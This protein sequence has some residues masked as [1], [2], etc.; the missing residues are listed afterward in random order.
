MPSFIARSPDRHWRAGLNPRGL[1]SQR[2]KT[3]IP[4][5]ALQAPF[6]V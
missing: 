6:Q 5:R 1:K 3:S 4:A 2:S